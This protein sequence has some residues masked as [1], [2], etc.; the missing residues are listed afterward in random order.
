MTAVSILR[1]EDPR[2]RGRLEAGPEREGPGYAAPS[3]GRPRLPVTW[4]LVLLFVAYPAWWLLGVSAFTWPIIAVPMLL[5]LISRRQ[6]RAPVAF[7]F[8]LAFTSWVLISGLQLQ[9]S[10][11]I[12][13]FSYR[14][15][16]YAVAG[17]LFLYVYNLPRASRLDT[18]VLRIVTIFWMVVVAGG[19]AGIL[20][21]SH[22]FV[23]PLMHILPHGL[24]SQPFVQELVQPVFAN[25]EGFLGYPVPRPSAPFTY[26]N[27]WGGNIAVLTPVAI[28]A[29]GAAGPGPRRKLIIAVLVASLVPMVFSLNRGMFLSLGVGM[30]YVTIRL[31]VRGRF[32]ALLSLLAVTALMVAILAVTPLG[33]LLLSGISGSHGHSNATRVSLYQQAWAG[34]NQSPWFGHGEPQPVSGAVLAG[35]PAIGTQGQLWTVLYSN[36]YPAT[37]FFLGF[38]IAAFWQ[39]RRARGVGGLWLHAVVVIALAQIAVYGYLPVELQVI[40]VVAAL[41]YRRCWRP[42]ATSSTGAAQAGSASVPGRPDP[43]VTLVPPAAVS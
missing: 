21:G 29:A 1:G 5:T 43:G 8:W 27:N 20:L 19:Y 13:T 22:T 11:R 30:V 35:T 2:D 18:R 39:T 26:T 10:T 16:L 42:A 25:V 24:R 7:I 33:H 41:A 34:A 17:V 36:G 40:M 4:P 12:M 38:F 3:E 9:S 37:V 14:L 15:S 28:A 6:S 31:A 23:P 32:G